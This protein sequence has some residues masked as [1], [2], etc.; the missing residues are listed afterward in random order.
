MTKQFSQLTIKC[1]TNPDINGSWNIQDVKNEMEYLGMT[2]SGNEWIEFIISHFDFPPEIDDMITNDMV[3]TL[4]C[5][6]NGDV[7]KIVK[8]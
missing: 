6:I 5:N 2:P 7:V 3:T 1:S 8:A 4:I